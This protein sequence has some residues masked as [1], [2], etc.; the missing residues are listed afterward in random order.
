MTSSFTKCNLTILG[1]SSSSKT[2]N[3]VFYRFLY[4]SQRFTFGEDG[5]PKSPGFIWIN[6]NVYKPA[7]LIS[8][9]KGLLA[10]FA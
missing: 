5:M 4:L 3:G 9:S 7:F 10:S 2:T 1:R 6:A 8:N